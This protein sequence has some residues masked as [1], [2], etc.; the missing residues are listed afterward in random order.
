M[1]QTI[2]L[3]NSMMLKRSINLPI[4]KRLLRSYPG[5]TQT[6]N[7]FEKFNQREQAKENYFIR[8]HEKE[9]MEEQVKHYKEQIKHLNSKIDEIE[10]EHAKKSQQKD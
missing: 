4:S 10:K 5:G 2:P 6:L 1:L 3:R 7:G 8:K 9:Q